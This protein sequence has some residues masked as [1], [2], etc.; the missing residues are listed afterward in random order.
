MGQPEGQSLR[1]APVSQLDLRRVMEFRMAMTP[2]AA[3]RAFAKGAVKL[4][5]VTL[6]FGD[7]FREWPGVQGQLLE[8]GP[9]QLRLGPAPE[10]AQLPLGCD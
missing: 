1:G 7:F 9:R 2:Q 5:G 10:A 6:I 8:V 4:D 3:S